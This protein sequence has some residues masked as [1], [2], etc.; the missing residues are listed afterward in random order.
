MADDVFEAKAKYLQSQMISAKDKYERE[1]REW[2]SHQHIV[3]TLSRELVHLEHNGGKQANIDAIKAKM[4]THLENM[5]TISTQKGESFEQQRAAEEAL[6]N[7]LDT[8]KDVSMLQKYFF[9]I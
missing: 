9:G 2:D 3:S 4:A 5:Q 1:S 8:V 7:H 6:L